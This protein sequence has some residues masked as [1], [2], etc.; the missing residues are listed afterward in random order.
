VNE[1][2]VTIELV[3]IDSGGAGIVDACCASARVGIVAEVNISRATEA[4]SIA[5][6][7]SVGNDVIRYRRL[8][9]V[10]EINRTIRSRATVIIKLVATYVGAYKV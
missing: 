4:D 5:R 1:V 6:T 10:R 2:T 3:G 7:G 9:T 8:V